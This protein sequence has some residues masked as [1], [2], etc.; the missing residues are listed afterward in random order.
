MD[1]D[2]RIFEL[3]CRD[4]VLE[5]VNSSKILRQKLTLLE[6]AR[7]YSWTQKLSYPLIVAAILNE[8]EVPSSGK[9]R[10]WENKVKIAL[11]YG[12]AAIA[13]GYVGAA[14]GQ[15]AKHGIHGMLA[16][17]TVGLLATYL[18]RKY[19]DACR[20]SCANEG[21]K[22]NLCLARC[23]LGVLKKVRSEFVSQK[24]K[25]NDTKNPKKCIKKID[26]QIRKLQ[27][28]EIKVMKKLRKLTSKGNI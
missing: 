3:A 16:G 23:Q 28:K 20:K 21:E 12:A 27:N 24:S 11:K 25:C 1:F 22:T 4:Y 26:N 10:G 19:S 8:Q 6:H 2:K 15:L 18:F 7:L 9:I 5:S 14:V 17:I 13:G